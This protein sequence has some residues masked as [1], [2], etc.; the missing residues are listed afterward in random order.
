MP[1]NI[2][3]S[4]TE[5]KEQALTE[6]QRY[7]IAAVVGAK[8]GSY[9][10]QSDLEIAVN[11]LVQLGYKDDEIHGIMS[12]VEDET[13]KLTNSNLSDEQIKQELYSKTRITP[14]GNPNRQYFLFQPLDLQ[15]T[16]E[17]QDIPLEPTPI[18]YS[19]AFAFGGA[20]PIARAT[21]LAGKAAAAATIGAGGGAISPFL[22]KKPIKEAIKEV[23]K[24][25]A[26]GALVY[27][28]GE[29]LGYGTGQ[30]IKGGKY[31]VGRGLDLLAKR[32]AEKAAKI[33]AQQEA[34]RVITT[35]GIGT[36]EEAAGRIETAL[37]EAERLR[38]APVSS[39]LLRG[40]LAAE[41]ALPSK[42]TQLF[43][44]KPEL[45]VINRQIIT[46]GFGTVKEAQIRMGEALADRDIR[47]QLIDQSLKQ[48][49][50]AAKLLKED[51]SNKQALGFIQEKIKNTLNQI[52]DVNNKISI[53]TKET[54]I[55]P[56][57]KIK[58]GPLEKRLEFLNNQLNNLS[59][60]SQALSSKLSPISSQNIKP[61]SP[62]EIVGGISNSNTTKLAKDLNRTADNVQINVDQIIKLP[63]DKYGIVRYIDDEFGLAYIETAGQKIEVRSV[64][65]LKENEIKKIASEPEFMV[66]R[67]QGE[68]TK[69]VNLQTGAVSKKPQ[70]TIKPVQEEPG[71]EVYVRYPNEV[72][73]STDTRL[74]FKSA[75]ERLD[76]EGQ[77]LL[78]RNNGGKIIDNIEATKLEGVQ[79]T[80]FD[81]IAKQLGGKEIPSE[82][83][84]EAGYIP[85][86][87]I[88]QKSPFEEGELFH[89]MPDV[90]P[91]IGD[92]AVSK[93]TNKFGVIKS[94][95]ENIAEFAEIT[96]E[97]G[98]VAR[99]KPFTGGKTFQVPMDDLGKMKIY[100][101]RTPF[102]LNDRPI[103]QI[104]D[105]LEKKTGLPFNSVFHTSGNKAVT[106][107]VEMKMSL[108]SKRDDIFE[109][110]LKNDKATRLLREKVTDLL[111]NNIQVIN[112]DGTV[113]IKLESGN[114]VDVPIDKAAL[115]LKENPL[116]VKSAIKLR[117]AYDDYIRGGAISEDHRRLFYSP[118]SPIK[119]YQDMFKY[120]LDPRL[121]KLA[122]FEHERTGK[123]F[124]TEKDALRSWEKYISD[125]AQ[126]EFLFP[127]EEEI[128][129]PLLAQ[130]SNNQTLMSFVSNYID[131]VRGIP[132][133]VTIDFNRKVYDF[134]NNTLGQTYPDL[135]ERFLKS[136][137]DERIGEVLG[138]KAANHQFKSLLSWR[139]TPILVQHTQKFL[140][141]PVI[142]EKGLMIGL[143]KSLT[144]A[145][146]ARTLASGSAGSFTDLLDRGVIS[147]VG[148]IKK[149]AEK[150]LG[151]EFKAF[152]PGRWFQAG[153]ANNRGAVYNYLHDTVLKGWNAGAKNFNE[154]EKYTKGQISWDMLPDSIVDRFKDLYNSGKI[155]DVLEKGTSNNAAHFIG[156]W[157]QWVTQ[158]PNALG[159]GIQQFNKSPLWKQAGVFQSYSLF[160]IDYLA[161]MTKNALTSEN[162]TKDLM[163]LGRTLAYLT[164][165]ES[166]TLAYTG[167]R[168]F[169]S[170]ASTL[171]LG[172]SPALALAVGTGVALPSQMKR[173]ENLIIGDTEK[174]F[175]AFERSKAQNDVFRNLIGIFGPVG[176]YAI[177]KGYKSLTEKGK[178]TEIEK[179]LF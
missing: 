53:S 63:N 54:E 152:T 62:S 43:E 169:V 20:G 155:G 115:S 171:R 38:Q 125:W 61:G 79:P 142:G 77:N 50:D 78:E 39:Q 141:I 140:A 91:N 74:D 122:R 65:R 75:S 41:E 71:K 37:T 113:K 34:A 99:L 72:T 153:D 68:V 176:S 179:L 85:K 107:A 154:L 16:I 88:I 82:L 67:R 56:T 17:Q 100:N 158:F 172:L 92:F 157:G 40:E 98:E 13:L 103:Y 109:G 64:N 114:I 130:I 8:L 28:T 102:H 177:Y 58:I 10:L 35:P 101:P 133:E 51:L 48:S 129:R 127:W 138:N 49:D 178:K 156:Y 120:N 124:Q 175:A 116:V 160:F 97:P 117:N 55:T 148:P 167:A 144:P 19:P 146:R 80:G 87:T 12:G 164:T 5:S 11:N 95:K 18:Y 96:R 70:Y 4:T 47:T 105:F 73:T 14:S 25:V 128:G 21:G 151:R 69:T 93:S 59:R 31:L 134:V 26:E 137:G 145:G 163:R 119:E 132:N 23:P 84:P 94:I 90:Q 15:R 111:E 104:F 161:K 30:V 135:A 36:V 81:Q 150:A 2:F 159:G 32:N 123:L 149:A 126:A 136:F 33:A 46:P 27:G 24:S 170:P 162:K 121:D 165:I 45:K 9:A 7:P 29:V 83:S 57:E 147:E 89:I 52:D 86:N 131:K 168:L 106:E 174:S 118:R 112:P 44:K 22:E 110:L 76:V 139:P 42:A 108:L 3:G 60:Q 66:K 1:L 166:L 6:Q 173:L 143:A